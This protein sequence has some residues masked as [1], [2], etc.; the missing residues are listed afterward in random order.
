MI[1]IEDKRGTGKTSRLLLL[2][3]EQGHTIVVSNPRHAGYVDDLAKRYFG[4]DHGINIITAHKFFDKP[5][6]R[7]PNETYL[8]DELEMVLEAMHVAG[9]SK[10]VGDQDG[11]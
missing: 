6:M 7:E 4:P 5:W 8:I 2:A 9:Y 3:K 1:R 11:R 10:S